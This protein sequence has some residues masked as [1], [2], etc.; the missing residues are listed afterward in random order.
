MYILSE[1][2][3]AGKLNLTRRLQISESFSRSMAEQVKQPKLNPP[4]GSLYIIAFVY[5]A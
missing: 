5:I 1:D 4:V 3:N 2:Y